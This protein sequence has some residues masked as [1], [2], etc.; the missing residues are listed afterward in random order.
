MASTEAR[1]DPVCGV[2]VVPG[3]EAE[4]LELEGVDYFFC[5]T[6]CAEKFRADPARYTE[7]QV[8]PAKS[9]DHSCCEHH[10]KNQGIVAQDD[11]LVIA[12]SGGRIRNVWT[13]ALLP[14]IVHA[15]YALGP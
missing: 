7:G 4:R 13:E 12:I 1:R 3:D 5:S 2:S 9:P 8:G 6:G 15:M 11:V 14:R 10:A